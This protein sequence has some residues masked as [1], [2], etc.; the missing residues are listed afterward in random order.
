MPS[1]LS[2]RP[3]ADADEPRHS[4]R[5]GFRS[6]RL[7]FEL[8][9]IEIDQGRTE[10]PTVYKPKQRRIEPGTI[11]AGLVALGTIA[12]VAYLGYQA[13]R[14]NLD[15]AGI[16]DGAEITPAVA[17]T[18]EVKITFSSAD[19]ASGAT[20]VFDGKKVA[21]PGVLGE[22][23][24]WRPDATL[25]EGDHRLELAVP[26]AVLDDAR[27]R[28]DFTVDGTPPALAVPPTVEPVGMDEA[29]TV[30]GTVEPGVKLTADGDEVDVDGEGRFTLRFDRPPVG[31]IDL[32]AVDSAGNHASAEVV[33]PI[34]YPG[35][36][37]VHVT[38]AAWSNPTLRGAILAMIDEKRIDT[39]QLDLKDDSGMV[40]YD[41]NVPRAREIGAVSGTYDLDGAITTL[42][43]RGVRVIGRIAAFRDPV[44]SEAAWAAGQGDQVIQTQSGDRYTAT[45]EFTNPASTAVRAYNLDIALEAIGRGVDDILWD[46]VRLP[47]GPAESFAVPGIN[48][49]PADVISAF[50]AE[51]HDELRRRGVYQGVTVVGAAADSGD[52]IGQDVDRVARHADYV[53]P[54]IYPGYWSANQHGVPD[55]PHMPGEMAA[56]L[57]TRYQQVTAGSGA[58]LVPWLQDY[59]L[60]GVDYGDAEV[61]AQ[62]DALRALGVDRFLLWSPTVRYS[63]GAVDP[64]S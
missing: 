38:A 15:I 10:G 43:A 12:L 14:V 21:E 8:P 3:D 30:R 40:G 48:G 6:G 53:A 19:E 46:D 23:M 4:R 39:V 35:V 17:A 16:E 55:P 62:I 27:F 41:S 37:G 63:A 29:A 61:R 47:T 31:P 52:R 22:F 42:D 28:W 24:V 34:T 54:Q 33:V 9:A 13:T 20:L 58:V 7:E 26:R 60:N 45:G 51:T 5:R 11:F 32:S 49:S 50:L 18:L 56:A 44:L 36:R 25:E 2:D 1:S 59:D 64:A 57:V